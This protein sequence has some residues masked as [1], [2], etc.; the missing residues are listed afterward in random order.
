[1]PGEV[2]HSDVQAVAQECIAACRRHG[3]WVGFGGV[4]DPAIMKDYTAQ[5]M[6][7]VLIGSDLGFLMAGVA[8]RIAMLRGT[9]G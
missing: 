5:G 6:N 1:M 4:A 9:G 7:F 3:K 2:A 8:S